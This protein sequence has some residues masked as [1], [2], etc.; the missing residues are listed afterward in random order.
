MES[1]ETN[2]T[3]KTF[4]KDQNVYVTQS[5]F[6]VGGKTYAM[7]NISSVTNYRTEKSKAGA[8]F[9]ILIGLLALT[10]GGSGMTFGVIMIAIGVLI[11]VRTKDDYSVQISSNSGESKAL[12]SKN[13]DY[14]QK[15]V[16]SV[17]EVII[18]RG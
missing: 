6:V 3:E 1:N 15:I 2:Q 11:I 4:Y 17:N 9:L 8:I 16:D 5:R 13:R 10:F 12:V 14:I 7:R 18:F